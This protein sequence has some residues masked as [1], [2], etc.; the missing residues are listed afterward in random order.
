MKK[1]D[2]YSLSFAKNISREK[3]YY[4]KR[5]RNEIRPFFIPN[6]KYV[7]PRSITTVTY[8]QKRNKNP[9]L[10][11]NIGI[12]TNLFYDPYKVINKVNN[13]KTENSPDLKAME[14][15]EDKDNKEE[16]NLPGYMNNIHN[17]NSL[18]VFT[19]KTLKMNNYINGEMKNLFSSFN[20]KSFNLIIN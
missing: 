20:K 15:R 8:N 7:E 18:G 10:K 17:R 14:G 4:L 2:N 16:I 9:P 5:D 6:Y 11:R 13:H 3:Y 19:K 1:K 12:E